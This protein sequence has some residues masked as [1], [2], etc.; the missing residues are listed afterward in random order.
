MISYCHIRILAHC[1]K[2]PEYHIAYHSYS[3]QFLYPICLLHSA[4][5]LAERKGE[6][7]RKREREGGRARA[8]ESERG[9]KRDRDREGERERTAIT[10][11]L[12]ILG[13]RAEEP[14]KN[15]QVVQRHGIQHRYLAADTSRKLNGSL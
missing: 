10:N 14:K 3:Y 13:A 12:F 11:I 7:V 8:R 4:E 15:D 5:H 9:S 2:E 1:Q 6:R